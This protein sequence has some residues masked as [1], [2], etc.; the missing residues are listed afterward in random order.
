MVTRSDSLDPYRLVAAAALLF[1]V[2]WLPP[3]P[4]DE[5]RYLAVAWNMHWRADWLVPWLDGMPYPDKPPLLFWLINL[6]WWV[7]GVHAWTARLLEVA[8]ALSTLPL[9]RRL[10]RELGTDAS[11]ASLAGWLW[12]GSL[13]FAGYAGAVMFD[14]LLCLC[15]LVAWLGGVRLW[16]G[17]RWTGAAMLALGLGLG[18]LAK[19]PVSLLVGGLPVLLGPW[20]CVPARRPFLGPYLAIALALLGGAALALAWAVPAALRGG[21]DYAN[22]I[23]LGQTAGRVAESFA[24]DRGPGW[25]LP[26]VPVLLLP[27]LIGL[28]RAGPAPERGQGDLR[29]DRFALAATLP[30]FLAFCVISG[31]QPHYLLP[32][33]PALAP[34]AAVRL[35]N[36]RWRVVGWRIGLLLLAMAVGA[37]LALARLVPRAPPGIDLA[38]ALAGV[39]GAVLLWRGRRGLDVATAALAMIAAAVLVKG[40]VLAGSASRYSV[41]TAARMVATAQHAGVPLLMLNRQNGLFTFAGRLTAAI[42]TAPGPRYVAA[43]VRAHPHG[44]VI[45]SD[46]DHGYAAAPLYRQPF[47]GRRLAIWRATDVAREAVAA[48][49]DAVHR[50]SR[51]SKVPVGM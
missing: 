19:G 45:S 44:W 29:C 1:A 31:K 32:L 49:A 26:I 25:Y 7:T 47:L 2:C 5:T 14:M 18:L 12:L 6:A 8:I 48:S 20:W 3:V 22:A 33:V 51:A 10:A 17:R 15:V 30:A 38:L 36:G 16:R 27:W 24:H 9:L 4:I 39:A 13:A 43:W 23:F 28:G 40:A 11:A 42:P 21:H 35:A 46:Q 34:A 41:A 50:R 37:W